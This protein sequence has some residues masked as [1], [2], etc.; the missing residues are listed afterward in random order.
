MENYIAWARHRNVSPSQKANSGQDRAVSLHFSTGVK[1][2]HRLPESPSSVKCATVAPDDTHKVGSPSG[3]VCPVS[4]LP[5]KAPNLRKKTRRMVPRRHASHPTL[6]LRPH[7]FCR[8]RPRHCIHLIH[9][10][11]SQQHVLRLSLHAPPG[12]SH[13]ISSVSI[14][15]PLWRA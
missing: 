3:A 2:M 8:L 10:E 6:L 15:V 1:Q 13:S 5:T 11:F 4:P 12:N 9:G 7:V 14:T